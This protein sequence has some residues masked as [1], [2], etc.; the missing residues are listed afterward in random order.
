[1]ASL[2]RAGFGSTGVFSEV[3]GPLGLRLL[4]VGPSSV[5]ALLGG[6]RVTRLGS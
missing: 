2:A 1:M 4:A 3:L 5:P 6:F